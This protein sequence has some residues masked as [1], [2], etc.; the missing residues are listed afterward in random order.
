[1]DRAEF[2][3]RKRDMQPWYWWGVPTFFRCPWD[4]DPENCDIGLVGVPH[5]S[6]NGSTERD[7]HLAPRVVRDVSG[8]YRRPHEV[9]GFIPWDAAKI[10]DLGDVPLPEAMVNDITVEHIEEYFRWLDQAG[11]HPVSIGG[12]HAITGPILKALGGSGT[13]LSGGRKLSLVQFDAHR[14]DYEHMPHWLGNRRSAAHWAAY[15][16]NEGHVDPEASVQIGIRG[17]QSKPRQDRAQ[18]DA[19]YR[20]LLA[21]TVHEKG[22]DYAID[23]MRERVGDN[24]IY[25]SFDLDS[26][27]PADAPGVSNLEAGYAGL[28]AHEA[29]RILHG[30]R[31]LNV[32]GAD[33]VCMMPTVDN[34]N[35]ITALNAMVLMFE[36]LS[37]VADRLRQ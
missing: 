35:R 31:G 34:P 18:S 24:P 21:D 15:T 2:E 32:V 17:N 6:G 5:S 11:T 33:I 19:G 13:N 27:D 37:L 7:Q 12:D 9:F 14:D 3:R 25:I 29:I 4:E 10:H 8:R 1:M 23:A 28:R 16:A 30:L 20:V 36:L 26:L 22:I